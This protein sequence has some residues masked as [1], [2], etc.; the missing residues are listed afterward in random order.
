MFR[1]LFIATI[2]FSALAQDAAPARFLI[3]RIEVRNAHRVSPELVISETLL[4][5][6]GEYSEEELSAASARLSRLPFLVSADFALEKG[7][8]R[9]RHVLVINVAE[10]K[11]FFFL[12]DARPILH[13][14]DGP[15]RFEYADDDLGS[16]SK[17]AALG[18]RWFAGRR[19]IVHVGVISRNARHAFMSDY[20]A[21]AVGYTQ[22]DLFGTRAFATVNI[23][24]PFGRSPK[25]TVSPE[26]VAGI[27]LTTNQT[28]TLEYEDT[29]FR[30]D[31]QRI[32]DTD[33]PR[34]DAE[35]VLSFTWTYNST[36]DPFAPT[37][38]TIVRISP[39]RA[40]RDRSSFR[41]SGPIPGAVPVPYANH[42]NGNGIDLLASRYW[43]LSERNAVSAGVLA[44]WAN[45]SDESTA[46]RGIDDLHW[47]PAYQVLRA[48]YSRNL[49]DG[50]SKNGDS[51]LELDVRVVARQLNFEHRIG[52]GQDEQNAL[53][54]AVSWVRRSAWGMLRLGAG[55]AWGY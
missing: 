52:Y 7:S 30:N 51:R 37:R 8:D 45:V 53:Q 31:T 6:G 44:G 46:A 27:P 38:G 49:W 33:I 5:E 54:G 9:G 1:T 22:Y 39:L 19:G 50:D 16:Q 43:E 20:S 18:F 34:R 55:Y 32:L 2:A 14:D 42:I 13:E 15:S 10:T 23:R 21:L 47:R 4:R 35:R 41:F 48:G 36:N 28:L 12:V 17:D 29:H 40:M 24:L 25:G 26:V 3:E 11:P